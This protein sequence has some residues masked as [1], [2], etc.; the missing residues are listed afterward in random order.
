[1]IFRK[2]SGTKDQKQFKMQGGATVVI[3]G[4]DK[5]DPNTEWVKVKV[6]DSPYGKSVPAEHGGIGAIV[7]VK[8]EWI[9]A[10]NRE[11]EKELRKIE[12]K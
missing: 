11:I 8:K 12:N 9:Q 10:N 7:S 4:R 6:V 1:M 5:D 2:S 3:V